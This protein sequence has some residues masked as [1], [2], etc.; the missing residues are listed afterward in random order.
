MTAPR[1]I[2][3]SGSHRDVGFQAGATF[4]REIRNILHHHTELQQV[5]LPYYRTADGRRDYQRYLSCHQ[6][7]CPE[8]LEELKGM[9]QGAGCDFSA[10]FLANLRGEFRPHQIAAGAEACSTCTVNQDGV[11]CI[12]HNED[13][14]E[15]FRPYLYFAHVHV[16]GRDPFLALSYPGFLFGNAVGWNQY[17]LF[18]SINIT[19]P[20]ASGPGIGR[21]FLARRLLEAR[22]IAQA[23]SVATRPDRASGFNYT[24]AGIN[25]KEILNIEVARRRYSVKS[26]ETH[27]FHTNHYVEMRGIEQK[28]SA[29]SRHR[30][31]RGRA[32]LASTKGPGKQDI[33]AILGDRQGRFPIFRTAERPEQTA[34]LVSLCMDLNQRK[35]TAYYG[36]PSKEPAKYLDLRVDQPGVPQ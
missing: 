20:R 36:N 5:L 22:T 17:G 29:S 18:F 24:I 1:R 26:I 14:L 9:A 32:L 35:L 16:Y 27:Y 34:T 8:Y 25:S 19:A 4:A 21:C 6:H 23:K 30:L 31:K 33:L 11:C 13:A 12:G 3:F 10:L 7:S 15:L 2:H 28:V